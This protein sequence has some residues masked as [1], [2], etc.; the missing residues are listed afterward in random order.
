MYDF[1]G[2]SRFLVPQRT[3]FIVNR[4]R[5]EASTLDN[6]MFFDATAIPTGADCELSLMVLITDFQNLLFN[7]VQQ[8]V[9]PFAS[10]TSNR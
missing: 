7:R 2:Q 9:S 4:S 6:P 3:D 10:I 8:K 5:F 1:L